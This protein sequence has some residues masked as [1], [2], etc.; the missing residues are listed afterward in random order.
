[1]A[2]GPLV[3]AVALSIAAKHA[4]VPYNVALV[5]GGMLLS[6]SGLLPTLP[7]LQPEVVFLVCLP[8]LLFEGGIA[9]DIRNTRDNALPIGLLATLGMLIV[10]AVTALALRP[11]LGLTWG[12]AMLLG[13][14]LSVTDTVLIP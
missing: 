11:L 4:R 6:I 3:A 14:L 5:V 7:Q 9:A 13:T 10:I 1:M 12:A 2:I 8:A